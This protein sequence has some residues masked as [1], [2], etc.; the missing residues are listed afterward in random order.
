MRSIATKLFLSFLMIIGVTSVIFSVVGVRA[1][2]DLVVSE[3]QATVRNDL[4]AA[5]EIYQG[6]LNQVNDAVRFAADRFLLLGRIFEGDTRNA[7]GEL[8]RL[9]ERERLDVLTVTDREGKVLLRVNNPEAAGDSQASDDLVQA[10]LAKKE[11]VS[12]TAIVPA[13]DLRRES[14]ALAE[15]A[16]FGFIETPKARPRRET[17]ETSGMML[18]AAAPVFDAAGG[19]KGTVYGGI[20]LNRDFGI[21]DKV[22]QTVFQGLKYEGKDIGTATLFQDDVRV[23][24]NVRNLDGSRAIGTRVAEDVYRRVVKEGLPWVDRAFVVNDWYITAYEPIRDFGGRIVGILYVGVLEQ[25]FVDMK[26]KTVVTVIAITGGGAIIAMAISYLLSR[27]ISVP[28]RRLMAAS[29][30]VASG[31]LDAKVDVDTRDELKDMAETFNRMASSLKERDERLKEYAKRKILESERLA[32]L[33]QL[34]AGVAHELNNPLQGIVT[35]SHL[36]LEE[37]DLKDPQADFLRKIVKQA[38]RCSKIIRGLLDFS[39]QRT[40]VKTPSDVSAILHECLSLVERQP[41]FHNIQVDRGAL[42]PL[43]PV[44]VD[45][46]QIQQVFM[47]LILNAA[48]AMNGSGCLTLATRFNETQKGV[49]IAIS[50]TGRG[51]PAEQMEKIFEPFFTTKEVGRGTGLGLAIC[52]GIVKGHGG[53]ISV[54]SKVGE[55]TTFTIRLPADGG[56]EA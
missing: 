14:P 21:V 17:E 1:V 35:Y 52:Y 54:E 26:K 43:P 9:K 49:E 11:P 29:R 22:K 38:D 31:N 40:A 30:E 4:N 12:A 10:A 13:E 24:T 6:R 34:A 20:L 16:R 3:A 37:K 41:L 28:V 47:N 19:L 56:R 42:G 27:T 23:S 50:D 33:G 45:P 51:I 46:S 32:F 18:K 8:K 53:S 44:V 36:L 48:E 25:K 55:G 7:V 15:R 5:R 2:D 39:R